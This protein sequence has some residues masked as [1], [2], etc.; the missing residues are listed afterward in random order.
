[1]AVYASYLLG[2]FDDYNLTMHTWKCENKNIMSE[3]LK[4]KA[5]GSHGDYVHK[6]WQG[7]DMNT[8][9]HK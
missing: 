5:V 7:L 3:K 6:Y 2:A 4:H 8:K 1:M 9:G